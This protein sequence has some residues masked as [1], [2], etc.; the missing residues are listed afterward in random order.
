MDTKDHA[1]VLAEDLA[2][3]CGAGLARL[4]VGQA[5]YGDD[6]FGRPRRELVGEVQQELVDVVNWCFIA[7][8]RARPTDWQAEA[9]AF[10]RQVQWTL[11][12]DLGGLHIVARL[13]VDAWLRLQEECR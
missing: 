9:R 8:R 7:T 11:P 12:S 10:W 2:E 1:R 3:M 6:S 4:E 5:E 13:A